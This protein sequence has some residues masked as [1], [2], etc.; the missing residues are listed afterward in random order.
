MK[1][2]LGSLGPGRQLVVG[3]IEAPAALV[4]MSARSWRWFVLYLALSG[5]LLIG[6]ALLWASQE[7]TLER[8]LFAFLFPA[9]W[10]GVIDFLLAFVFK[11]QAQQVVVNVVIFITLT[12]VSL[13][14]F[15]VK[16]L[17][18]QS[19]ER[20]LALTRAEADPRASWREH[21]VWFQALEEI[22]W[23]LV[24]F[25]LMFVVLWVGHSPEPWRKTAATVLSYAVLFFVTAGNYLAP[26]MQRR[27]L[28]YSQVIKSIFEKPLLAL[29]FGAAVSLPQ[30]AVLHLVSGADLPALTSLLILF[31]VN[32][33]FIAASAVTGTRAGLA[34]LPA[35][36]RAAPSG[37]ATRLV[38]WALVFGV[39]GA[40]AWVGSRLGVSLAAKSQI[41]KCRYEVDWA[42]LK[43]DT[44]ELG[45][46]IRGEV[47]VAVAFDVTIDNP[48]PLPV[49]IEDNRLVVS[50]DA[51]VIAE[52]RLSPLDVPAHGKARTRV[53]LDA[54]VRA[55]SLL[56]GAS[57][58]PLRWDVTLYVALGEGLELPIYLR[59]AD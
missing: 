26:P 32:I 33:V 39:L 3:L 24:G 11:A 17:L 23:T 9:D 58:N 27:R 50:D 49:R 44:P 1:E 28:R 56:E 8:A 6:F 14:F 4:G 10:H 38:G 45:G 12:V 19:Y 16:E 7:E 46:L 42:T 18:S 53:A 41:L 59:G 15:W 22:K 40:G 37:L 48:N 43:L 57:I 54:K 25:A 35:A 20:D 31:A 52:S 29:S 34:L 51:L 30:V 13:V 55:T 47:K 21:P 36:A 2:A 5:A